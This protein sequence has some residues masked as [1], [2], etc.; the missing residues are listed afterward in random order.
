V[1]GRPEWVDERAYPFADHW[2]H[3]LHYVDEGAGLPVLLVHGNP[4]WS[5]LYRHVIRLAPPGVRCVAPDL[6]GFGLS[7]PGEDRSPAALARALE[8]F[9]L[10]L[11]LRDATL[12]VQDWGG[13]V[14]TW[15]AGRHPDRFARLVV[16]NTW[17]W[18]TPRP[19]ATLWSRSFGNDAVA[20]RFPSLGLQLGTRRRLSP[21]TIAHYVRA[22]R[23]PSV[24]ALI[25][26]VDGARPWLAEVQQGLGALR[27]HPARLV[28]PTADPVFAAVG[29]RP[30]WRDV[31][32]TLDEQ[33][34]PG[35][36][37]FC[38]EDDPEPIAASLS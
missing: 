38:Q 24:R 18:P 15:V 36:R 28:W 1:S 13:P 11:D 9:V 22:A 8:R 31:F 27:D 23:V 32:A 6:P 14:G 29:A 3:G 30:V 4:T 37:H 20:R 33:E 17:A 2:L 19:G 35:A 34:L 16:L 26:A 10:E 21:E 12:V 7:E 25:E 5:F